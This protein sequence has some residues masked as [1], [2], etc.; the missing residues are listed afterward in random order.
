MTGWD[1][2][3]AATLIAL[4]PA[5]T[6][7]SVSRLTRR[8][9]SGDARARIRYYGWGVAEQWTLTLLLWML[10]RWTGRPFADL[11]SWRP[12]ARPRGS[13]QRCAR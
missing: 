6:V 7:W 1:H 3:L 11:G 9:D 13:R 2:A 4:P 5:C 8:I 10:W 12:P